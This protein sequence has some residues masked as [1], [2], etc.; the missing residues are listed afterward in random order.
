MKHPPWRS[1]R[2]LALAIG[3]ALAVAGTAFA[4]VGLQNASFENGLAG[5]TA[6][7]VRSDVYTGV[8][9]VEPATCAGVGG[10]TKRGICAVGTDTFTPVGG[11]AIT[12]APLDGS[13][14]ARLAG[15][16]TSRA[17]DQELE[18]YRLR[19][20]FTVDPANPVLRLNYNVFLFDYTGFDDLR[21]TV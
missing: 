1:A 4:A 14:M 9:I 18:R 7:T 10:D 8:E 6:E 5:W 17:Q 2:V 13:A 15:P 12:V 16:F 11:S 21:F 20:T 3:C 19:Q